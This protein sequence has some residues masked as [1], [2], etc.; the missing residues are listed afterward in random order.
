MIFPNLSK[1]SFC[2]YF[3]PLGQKGLHGKSSASMVPSELQ[4]PV[5]TWQPSHP[6]LM[7]SY[8]FF[9]CWCSYNGCHNGWFRFPRFAIQSHRMWEVLFTRHSFLFLD[10][11]D[12]HL[13]WSGR[14][15]FTEFDGCAQFGIHPRGDPWWA[16]T[17]TRETQIL[18][19][20]TQWQSGTNDKFVSSSFGCVCWKFAGTT[21]EQDCFGYFW[22]I[23][24]HFFSG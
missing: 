7:F 10:R 16:Q 23:V 4:S 21:S 24:W 11:H 2:W 9:K 14:T 5:W 12:M 8:F 20:V 15:S 13:T 22:L 6:F 17:W 3:G 18:R 1:T 19:E